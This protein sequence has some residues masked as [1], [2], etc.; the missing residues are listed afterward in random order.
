[1]AYEKLE[2]PWENCKGYKIFHKGEGRMMMNIIFPNGDRTTTSYSRY[3]VSVREGRILESHE[4]VDHIDENKLND[5]LD[6]LQ[7][8]TQKFN[9]QKHI[10]C[11]G[12]KT[13]D[14]ELVCPICGN[15][16]YRPPR[17]VN[18]KIK[19]GHVPTCSR[20]CGG[21]LSHQFRSL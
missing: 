11:K 9:N 15:V 18:T 4:H 5:N 12:K 1:M 3:L 8:V 20:R 14:I 2:F 21:I 10:E 13:K 16:F 6:N 17:N 7:I 19:R